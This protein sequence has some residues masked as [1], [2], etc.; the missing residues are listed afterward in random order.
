MVFIR[1]GGNLVFYS[2]SEICELIDLCTILA[3]EL[4]YLLDIDFLSRAVI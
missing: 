2:L 1:K 4:V 3:Y